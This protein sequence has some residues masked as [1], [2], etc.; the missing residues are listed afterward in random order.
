MISITLDSRTERETIALGEA[1]GARLKPGDV[2][3]LFGEL[4]A[5]KTR[6]VRGIAAGMG[7]DAAAVSSPTYVLVQEYAPVEGDGPLLVHLDAY[8][9]SSADWLASIGWD[10]LRDSA[11]VV[12]IE[13]AD[14]VAAALP[15]EALA[16]TIEHAEHGRDAGSRR[17]LISGDSSWDERLRGLESSPWSRR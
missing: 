8:R 11:A 2:V 17:V 1:L 10:S 3:A 12:V 6:L 15:T 4:G 16:I 13:W 9:L 14:R 5:G 7:I